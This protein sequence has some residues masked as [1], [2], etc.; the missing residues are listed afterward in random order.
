MLPVGL[1]HV[2]RTVEVHVAVIPF[3]DSI[4]RQPEDRGVEAF[5]P[6][7]RRVRQGMAG[8]RADVRSRR[9]VDT[10]GSAAPPDDRAPPLPAQPGDAAAPPRPHR[11]RR[12]NRCGPRPAAPAPGK[13]PEVSTKAMIGN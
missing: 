1:E 2:D 7:D 10:A 12:R 9:Y 5:A 13:A 8:H 6:P 4:D 11:P 3:A